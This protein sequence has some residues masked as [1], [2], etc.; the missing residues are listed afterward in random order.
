MERVLFK[1]V[2]QFTSDVWADVQHSDEV[3]HYLNL[4]R[5]VDENHEI[6]EN[7]AEVWFGTRL[8]ANI[9][10]GDIQNLEEII[11][12]LIESIGLASGGT[13]P[14]EYFSGSTYVTCATTVTEAIS[15]LDSAITQITE[16]IEENHVEAGSGITVTPSTSGVTVSVRLADDEQVLSFL[17]TGELHGEVRLKKMIP[18]D[19]HYAAQY[20]LVDKDDNPIVSSATIDVFRD[21][22]LRR[23]L[24]TPVFET[25][26]EIDDWCADENIPDYVRDQMEI[27]NSYL[28]FEW[29]LDHGPDVPYTSA[30]TYTVIPVKQLISAMEIVVNGVSATTESGVTYINIDSSD[31]AIDRDI[32]YLE[33]RDEGVDHNAVAVEEGTNIT[34]AIDIVL[35]MTLLYI[36]GNDVE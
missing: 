35:N 24:L 30:D 15:I 27:D 12:N 16:I 21:Q 34:D 8:Y 31:I 28:V 7:E 1:G 13:Y 32:E 18:D 36:D 26:Q 9:G 11:N 2:K 6:I 25:Q 10:G 3:K 14:S 23:V 20:W 29:D 19:D 5:K 4:V 22:F 33:Y 17:P